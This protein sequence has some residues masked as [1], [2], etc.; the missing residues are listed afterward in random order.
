MK[1]V[2]IAEPGGPEKLIYGDRP[3]PEA[4]PGEVV[5]RVRGTAI[6][7]ADFGLR[8]N[9]SPSCR[10][11]SRILTLDARGSGARSRRSLAA[12][13]HMV[14]H[15]GRRGVVEH[16]FELAEAGKAH[17]VIAGRDFFG[18]LVLRVP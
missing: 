3:D 5:V 1:A 13:M 17:E 15:G 6:N 4:G 10:G 18:K 11:L 9:G 12:M 7:R 14:H 2:Y 8:F 16:T